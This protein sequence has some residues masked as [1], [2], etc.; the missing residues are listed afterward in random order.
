MFADKTELEEPFQISTVRLRPMPSE[1][2]RIN[3]HH[4]SDSNNDSSGDS[5]S[6]YIPNLDNEYLFDPSALGP[7]VETLLQ[8]FHDYMVGPDRQR[9]ARSIIVVGDIHRIFQAVGVKNDLSI[10]FQENGAYLHAKYIIQHCGDEKTKAISIKKYLYSLM[11]F[12]DFLLV[13]NIDVRNVD[14][15]SIYRLHSKIKQW[16]K[17][18]YQKEKLDVHVRRAKDEEMLVT[19]DQVKR[20]QEGSNCKAAFNIFEKLK[21]N[22]NLALNRSDFCLIRDHFHI[23]IAFSNAQ[24][25]GATANMTIQEFQAAKLQQNGK[26]LIEVWDHKTV[27]QFAAV[28]LQLYQKDFEQLQLFVYGPRK[29]M[30]V[31]SNAAFISWSG[32]KVSGGDV[33]KRLHLTWERAGNFVNKN[34]TKNFTATLIWKSA[35]TGLR[36]TNSDCLSEAADAMT[37]SLHTAE[38][39]YFV[40]SMK[41]SSVIGVDAISQFFYGSGKDDSHSPLLQTQSSAP[42]S[43]SHPGIENFTPSISTVSDCSTLSTPFVYTICNHETEDFIPSMLSTPQKR[44]HWSSHEERQIKDVFSEEE[45][46]FNLVK[47]QYSKVALLQASPRQVYDKLRSLKRR[48]PQQRKSK[49]TQRDIS[50]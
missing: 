43:S 23:N 6:E 37:H 5:D 13:E 22:I 18:F 49:F 31:A 30:Q 29:R 9:K 35:S 48:N 14:T 2:S 11:D 41:K 50:F 26:M 46:D 8:K 28:N 24:R 17:N 45:P 1:M 32:K 12:C 40:R 36:E 44:K 21:L 20:Y 19:V 25:S 47:N 34:I 7:S 4:E 39:H 27:V 38:Q 3:M 15:N 33:S 10:I 16:R 42:V